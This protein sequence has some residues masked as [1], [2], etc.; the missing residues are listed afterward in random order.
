M[1]SIRVFTQEIAQELFESTEKFPVSFDDA[2]VWLEFSRKD[3]A[4]RQFMTCGFVENV[5]YYL[6]KNG[7]TR[8]DNTFS[9][10]NEHIY[11][12]CDCFKSWGMMLKNEVGQRI[13]SY[14]LECERLLKAAIAKA[15]KPQTAIELVQQQLAALT[16]LVQISVEHEARLST[17]EQ[18]NIV[19]KAE[20]AVQAQINAEQETHL[21]GLDAE[22]ARHQN[23]DGHFYTV[24]GFA[25]LKNLVMGSNQAKGLGLRCSNYCKKNDI[26]HEKVSDTMWGQVGSYPVHVLETIFRSQNLI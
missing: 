3:H 1:T 4:K 25:N 20:L 19:L 8:L 22:L 16:T 2:W 21:K 17:I 6:P 14:F 5:D 26:Y 11:L 10:N 23:S 7:E 12:T 18:E 9:P 24:I 13:R 15:S